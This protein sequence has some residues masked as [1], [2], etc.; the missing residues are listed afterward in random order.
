MSFLTLNLSLFPRLLFSDYFYQPNK[1]NQGDWEIV[2]K[3]LILNK[4]K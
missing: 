3:F 2:A 1:K 4:F